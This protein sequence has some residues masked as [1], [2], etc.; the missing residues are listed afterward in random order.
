MKIIG[1]TGSIGMGKSATAGML[2]SLHV[3]VFDSDAYVHGVL[4]PNGAA[5]HDVIKAFPKAYDKRKKIIDRQALG[6]D[7]FADSQKRLLLE[8]IIHPH[9]WAGQKAFLRAAKARGAKIAVLDIPLLY[10]TGADRRCDEVIVV[11]A[12]EFIQRQRVLRRAGMD[13]A[14]FQNILKNQVPDGVKRMR[15]DHII[16]TGLGRAETLRRLKKIIRVGA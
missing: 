7:I 16:P 8:S 5:F 2:R 3:P 9:V 6:R 10:E 11:T 1:L 13:E 14:R 4:A 12:P 15:A